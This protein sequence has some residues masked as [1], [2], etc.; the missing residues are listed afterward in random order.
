MFGGPLLQMV[1]TWP[2]RVKGADHYKDFTQNNCLNGLWGE[3]SWK[4]LIFWEIEVE[5]GKVQSYIGKCV[6]L[7]FCLVGPC[8]E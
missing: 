2:R 6:G 7:L 4:T 8:T 3:H 1:F 5:D